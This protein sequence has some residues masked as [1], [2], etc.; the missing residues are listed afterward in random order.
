MAHKIAYAHENENMCEIK[1]V[2]ILLQEQ[3]ADTVVE[4]MCTEGPNGERYTVVGYTED[5]AGQNIRAEDI[6]QADNSVWYMCAKM[7]AWSEKT[8]A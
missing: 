4:Q 7:R 3:E 8:A 1:E 6:V 5:Q 2:V